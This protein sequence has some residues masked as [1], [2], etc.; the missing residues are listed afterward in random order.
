MGTLHYSAVMAEHFADRLSAAI[1]RCRTAAIV[2][3]DPRPERLPAALRPAETHADSAIAEAFERFG[4]A[5]FERIAPLVPAVKINIA[6][7]EPLGEAGIAAFWR[8]IAAAHQRGLM[9]IADTKRCDIGSTAEAYARAYL[10]DD[11]DRREPASL[12]DAVTVGGYFGEAGVGPFIE[13]AV[14][15]GRGVYVIVRPSDPAADAIHDHGD[16][17][18]YERLAGL[19]HQWGRRADAIGGCGLSCVGA[20]VAARDADE[21][22]RLRALMPEAPF[23]VPGYG[24]QGASPEAC[25]A[26]FRPDGSGAVISASRSVI[27]AYEDARRR[28][29]CGDDWLGCV[30]GACREFAAAAGRLAGLR[31][32]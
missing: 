3:F 12:P 22:A 16:P 4:R 24:A 29:R 15:S 28:A 9:V 21:T 31:R 23:L 7:F 19:V 17:P 1:G 20:V 10:G 26:A 11:D 2:G 32:G 30:E 27:Y 6:F 25:A 18:L 13:R 8:L 5:I 14:R